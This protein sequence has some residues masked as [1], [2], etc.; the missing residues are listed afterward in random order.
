MATKKNSVDK[1]KRRNANITFGQAKRFL[2]EQSGVTD[3]IIVG[4]FLSNWGDKFV[5]GGFNKEGCR[6]V[7]NCIKI[8]EIAYKMDSKLKK[9]CNIKC[10]QL[11]N[12]G[13]K[14]E[15]NNKG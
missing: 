14:N 15:E 5:C 4:C 2:I 10:L 13:N 3:D 7:G 9:V 12:G 6:Y 1:E 8:S 11:I